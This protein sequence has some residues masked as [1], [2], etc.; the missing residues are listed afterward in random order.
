VLATIEAPE[1]FDETGFG[2]RIKRTALGTAEFDEFGHSEY[3]ELLGNDRWRSAQSF[4]EVAYVH[5]AFSELGDD[6]Q[7]EG[8]RKGFKYV[9]S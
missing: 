7:P 9:C 6:H 1:Q 5:G 3:T 2:E 8:M 4:R